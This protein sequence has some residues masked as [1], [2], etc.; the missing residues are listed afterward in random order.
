MVPSK[1][2][3]EEEEEEEEYCRSLIPLK[4][5]DPDRVTRLVLLAVSTAPIPMYSAFLTQMS[6]R[7]QT[8][9]S[10]QNTSP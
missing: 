5:K 9:S 8:L 10:L 7:V 3:E 4:K 1:V 6:C 2:E